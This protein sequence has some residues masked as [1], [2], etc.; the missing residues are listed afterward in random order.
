M[1]KRKNGG[2]LGRFLAFLVIVIMIVMIVGAVLMFF[3]A[4]DPSKVDNKYK[5]NDNVSVAVVGEYLGGL[6]PLGQAEAALVLGWYGYSNSSLLENVK[7]TVNISYTEKD[8]DNTVT[9][10][11]S[12]IYFK[13][14]KDAN[15]ARDGVKDN[16]KKDGKIAMFRGK[17]LVVGDK[18]A[19]LKYYAVLF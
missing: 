4:P 14:I 1:A 13:N 12:I 16:A 19:A 2:V 9:Y 18:K 10:T 6:A 11:A 17:A 8:G 15:T 7:T 5:D 3:V